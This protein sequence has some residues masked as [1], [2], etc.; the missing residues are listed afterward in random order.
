MKIIDLP[1]FMNFLG[2]ED[3]A[4]RLEF[5]YQG[6]QEADGSYIVDTDKIKGIWLKDE[7]D[8]D[9]SGI[10]A[11]PLDDSLFNSLADY[12]Q[13]AFSNYEKN[14]RLDLPCTPLEFLK[15]AKRNRFTDLFPSDDIDAYKKAIA[16]GR[17]EAYRVGFNYGLT[18][19]FI[20]RNS[21]D[22]V[23]NVDWQP[24]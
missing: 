3:Y 11:K 17:G 22:G 14:I 21:G 9:N 13:K 12:E 10:R 6:K 5:S 8:I 2:Y 7:C 24:G 20:R 19:T 18:K 15:W 4:H 1:Q 16:D 23:F